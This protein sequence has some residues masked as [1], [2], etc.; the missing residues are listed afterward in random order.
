MDQQLFILLRL[1]M[2]GL[3]QPPQTLTLPSAGGAGQCGNLAEAYRVILQELF[4]H[5]YFKPQ[6]SI[7]SL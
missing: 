1:T 5:A 4:D 6:I 2:I 3:P 7:S